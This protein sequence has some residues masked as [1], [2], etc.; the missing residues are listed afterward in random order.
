MKLQKEP[1]LNTKT[2]GVPVDGEG[3]VY[4]TVRQIGTLK[5]AVAVYVALLALET[6][7]D[8]ALVGDVFVYIDL[9]GELGVEKSNARL[10]LHPING[11]GNAPQPPGLVTT[12]SHLRM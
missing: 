3:D 8:A 1:L 11:T 6:L 7:V 10:P 2:K 12:R 9:L 5:I 4:L